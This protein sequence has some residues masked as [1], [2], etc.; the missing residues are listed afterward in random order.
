M[1]MTMKKLLLSVAGSIMLSGAALA[2]DLPP[3]PAYKAP[4]V[5][6]PVYSWTGCYVAGGFGFGV[7]NQDHWE[8]TFPGLVP[9]QGRVTNGGRGWMGLAGGGCDVEVPVGM[10]GNVVFGVMG[11]Y[12]FMNVHGIAN[13]GFFATQGD[14][15]Q[16]SAWAVGGRVGV[17][18]SPNLLV[19]SNGG[20]TQSHFNQNNLQ[21]FGIG[22]V[23]TFTPS[24]TFN[25]WF[26][27]GGTE[28]ALNFSW[29]PIHGLFWRNE[30]RFSSFN[31]GDLQT[32]TAAPVAATGTAEHQQY[33]EQ[34]VLSELVWRFNWQ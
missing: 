9:V 32:F 5:A 26:V 2:A 12:D 16:S 31:K 20:F 6:A 3:A 22:P 11:D 18:I 27:G 7:W 13:N 1:G 30:Y 21:V 34:A 28:Y 14:Q 4:A 17:V 8:E 29:L 10:F 19:Y 15:K 24:H 33:Y 23:L 25:G